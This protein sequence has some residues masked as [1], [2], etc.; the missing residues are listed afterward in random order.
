MKRRDFLLSL[1]TVAALGAVTRLGAQTQAGGPPAPTTTPSSPLAGAA[2]RPAPP[3][4]EPVFTPLRRNVGYFTARGGTIGWLA[5]PDALAVVDTQFAETAALCL[6]GLPG[7]GDR[8]LDV[9]INTHHHGDHTSG[10]GVFK[11]ATKH[12]VAQANVPALQRRSAENAR[13][14]TVDKQVYADQTF[15]DSWSLPLGDEVVSAKFLGPAHTGGDIVVHFEKANVIHMGDLV[16]NRIYPVTDRNGAGNI[17][18]WVSVLEKVIRDYPADA[19][20]VFGHG[21]AKFGVTG[22]RDDIGVI[23]DYLSALLEYVQKQITT[24]K[25][26]EEVIT[27]QEFPGFPDFA[28]PGPNSRLPVNLGVAY[29][30]LMA[31]PS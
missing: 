26:K 19:I 29:D 24:G 2:P 20:Y 10:N 16:F 31:K 8:M 6:A 27:L 22:K 7:R 25:T 12:I 9:V 1:S 15:E 23:R 14:P 3:A 11:P 4:P 5:S 30:E 21:S 13:P 18:G 28:Q 17:R